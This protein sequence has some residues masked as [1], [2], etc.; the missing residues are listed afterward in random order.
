M[1]SDWRWMFWSASIF[2]AAMIFA[3]FFCFPETYG[4]LILRERARQLRAQTGNPRY[5]ALGERLDGTLSALALVSRAVSRPVR[6]LLFHPIIQVAS[7]KSAID[8]GILHIV[9]STFAELWMRQ[10]GQSVEI[11]GLHYLVISARPR[12]RAPSSEATSWIASTADAR[13]E[14]RTCPSLGCRTRFHSWSSAAEAC[15]CTAGLPSTSCI[16]QL[17]TSASSSCCLGSNPVAFLARVLPLRCGFTKEDGPN[18][19]NC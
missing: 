18:K 8:Y 13:S 19:E 7:I 17:S 15:S 2:Q 5:Y 3:S 16:G 14:A 1:R 4:P 11:S 9:L 10:Y 12:L 6:L